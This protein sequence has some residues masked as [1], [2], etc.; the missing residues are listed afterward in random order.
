MQCPAERAQ[1]ALGKSGA[2]GRH[3][4]HGLVR[5]WNFR[6]TLLRRSAAL[7]GRFDNVG[8]DP[9]GSAKMGTVI[10]FD[11]ALRLIANPFDVAGAE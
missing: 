10:A 3:L 4:H 11:A 6:A 9:A 1:P 8:P 7:A 2:I 5:I